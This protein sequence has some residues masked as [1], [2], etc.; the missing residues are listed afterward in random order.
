MHFPWLFLTTFNFLWPSMTFFN[1]FWPSLTPPYLLWPSLILTFPELLGHSLT[2]PGLL[3]PSLIFLD[4]PWPTLT[5]SDV[6]L[7]LTFLNPLWTFLT[8]HDLLRPF[9]PFYL[10]WPYFEASPLT[11]GETERAGTLH[12]G[13]QK[14]PGILSL[15]T[16]TWWEGMEIRDSFSGGLPS[17]RSRGDVH[18]IKKNQHIKFLLKSGNTYCE[19]DWALGQVAQSF[20]SLHPWRYSKITWTWSRAG[21][22]WHCLRGEGLEQ[23]DLQG[24][25][26][27]SGLLWFCTFK[28]K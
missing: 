10:P 19:G 14:A 27:T 7:S 16:N 8:I 18:K 3:Q 22:R 11:W 2:F 15:C 13:K 26:P 5:C 24:S 20:L 21:S 6:E 28:F 23:D 25:L 1:L 12:P 17:D 4:L 9:L